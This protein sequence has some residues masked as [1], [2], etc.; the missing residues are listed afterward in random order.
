M[1]LRQIGYFIAVAEEGNIGRAAVRLHISQPP[2]SRQIQKLED[3]LGISLFVRTPRG[4]ELTQGGEMFLSEVRNIRSL[5]ELAADRTKQAGQGKLGQLDVAIFG[6]GILD[7]IPKLLL[8][9]RERYPDVNVVLHTMGKDEQLQALRQRRITVGFNRLL[10]AVPDITSELLVSEQLLLAVNARNELAQLDAVPFKTLAEHSL[11]VFPSMGR[12]N[13]ADKII[14]LCHEAGF[15]PTISQEVGD[16]ITSIA[17]VA[18]GFGVCLVPESATR[19]NV[20]GVVYRP[21]KDAPAKASVDL[22]YI[23][24]ADDQSPLLAAFRESVEAFKECLRSGD[25]ADT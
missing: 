23:Y 1:D 6:S 9:F 21:L 14:S 24:R 2:L 15:E 3:E 13:F 18:S 19:V 4:V 17:L 20:P 10:P 5:I 25:C 11:V 8:F 7:T 16:A 12:P 22:S